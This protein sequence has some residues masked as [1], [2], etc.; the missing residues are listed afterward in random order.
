MDFSHRLWILPTKTTT[1]QHHK[2]KSESDKKKQLSRQRTE[3]GDTG[4]QGNPRPL[5][6]Q[7]KEERSRVTNEV[8]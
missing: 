7:K 4:N 6:P 1:P 3:L 2:R 8:R 5:H